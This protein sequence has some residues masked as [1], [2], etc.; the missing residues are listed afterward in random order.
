MTRRRYINKSSNGKKVKRKRLSYKKKYRGGEDCPPESFQHRIWEAYDAL[1]KAIIGM[2]PPGLTGFLLNGLISKARKFAI[3]T[4]I[5]AL[6]NK[7]SIIKYLKENHPDVAVI[8][9]ELESIS[10]IRITPAETEYIKLFKTKKTDKKT[11]CDG[12]MKLP[13]TGII[14]RFGEQFLEIIKQIESEIESKGKLPDAQNKFD[15]RVAKLIA[16]NN[17]TDVSGI[18]NGV[19][20]DIDAAKETEGVVE[21]PKAE[22]AVTEEETSVG[23]AAEE[24]PTV[25]QA[26]TEGEPSGATT[27]VEQS[28][29]K[30][31]TAGGSIK[32]RR[33]KKRRSLKNYK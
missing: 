16:D 32:I 6:K 33:N 21:E 8:P 25:G 20:N 13:P 5:T 26:A 19:N 1:N 4:L 18:L 14:R 27:Q 11:I 30:E 3:S 7:E 22:Q 31:L 2:R 28:K 12:Y 10:D 17:N 9:P 29:D 24:E 15:E 23:Q